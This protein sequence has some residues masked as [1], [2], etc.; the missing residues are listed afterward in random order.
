MG[1]T[2]SSDK[3]A[4]LRENI[5]LVEFILQREMI[6]VVIVIMS[7]VVMVVIVI[8]V[9]VVVMIMI[10][11]IVVVM[12]IVVVVTVVVMMVVIMRWIRFWRFH[13]TLYR[14]MRVCDLSPTSENQHRPKVG[15]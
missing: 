7:M 2:E 11:M 9:V 10:M 3:D 8:I 12:V 15:E 4:S 14:S 6:V 13:P 5:N 1:T